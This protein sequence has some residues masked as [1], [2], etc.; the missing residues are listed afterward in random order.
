M[1]RQKAS[2]STN[3]R[4]Q[5]PAARWLKVLLLVVLGVVLAGWGDSRERVKYDL[6]RMSKDELSY[7]YRRSGPKYPGLEYALEAKKLAKKLDYKEGIVDSICSE[8]AVYLFRND[9]DASLKLYK[10]GLKEAVRIGY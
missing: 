6:I 10:K 3:F 1:L 5:S 9:Y 8:A 7:R 2:V 4:E